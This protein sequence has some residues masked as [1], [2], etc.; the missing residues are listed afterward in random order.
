MEVAGFTSGNVEKEDI[1]CVVDVV[2]LATRGNYVGPLIPA[3]TFV[4][5][6]DTRKQSRFPSSSP[7]LPSIL[8]VN[9]L[10]SAIPALTRTIYASSKAATIEGDLRASAI[11]GGTAREA[12]PNKTGLKRDKVARR[13]IAALD[14]REKNVFM[15]WAMGPAHLLYWPAG[16]FVGVLSKRNRIRMTAGESLFRPTAARSLGPGLWRLE[17]HVITKSSN[18]VTLSSLSPAWL[19][20]EVPKQIPEYSTPADLL[21]LELRTAPRSTALCRHCRTDVRIPYSAPRLHCGLLVTCVEEQAGHLQELLVA[22]GVTRRRR[23][24]P[25]APQNTTIS[26]NIAPP[27]ACGRG[28]RRLL[29]RTAIRSS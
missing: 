9:A 25:A 21:D 19:Q 4:G 3:V 22:P 6:F 26:G 2:A 24:L 16:G 14:H 28:P 27:S 1:R 8:L 5:V 15:P 20:M 11:D 18:I 12:D 13:C 23:P 17:F 29:A 10:A 7:A